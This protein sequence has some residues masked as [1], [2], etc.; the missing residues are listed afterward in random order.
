MLN[1]SKLSLMVSVDTLC[2]A[3]QLNYYELTITRMELAKLMM[4]SNA[5]ILNGKCEMYLTSGSDKVN[6]FVK[7]VVKDVYFMTKAGKRFE[8]FWMARK[9]FEVARLCLEISREQAQAEEWMYE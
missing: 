7:V 9:K 3:A 4:K 1:E 8:N 2:E 5:T 6:A